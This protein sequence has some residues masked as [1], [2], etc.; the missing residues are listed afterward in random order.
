MIC[1]S[2]LACW[3]GMAIPSSDN[4]CSNS[5]CFWE[6]FNCTQHRYPSCIASIFITL[7]SPITLTLSIIVTTKSYFN[8]HQYNIQLLSC[9]TLF[10]V[11]QTIID[12]L[13]YSSTKLFDIKLWSKMY[14]HASDITLNSLSH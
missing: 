6:L 4:W 9:S 1:T 14:E 13:I 12:M 10:T 3:S 8:D 2:F 5:F 7:V 11:S